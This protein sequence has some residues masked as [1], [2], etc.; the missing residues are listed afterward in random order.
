[1]SRGNLFRMVYATTV[2]SQSA[3][4]IVNPYKLCQF[5]STSGLNVINTKV[6]NWLRGPSQ[7]LMRA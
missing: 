5:L 6:Y 7:V 1:M 4:Y 3:W 2:L